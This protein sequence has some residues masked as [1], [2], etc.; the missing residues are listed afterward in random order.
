MRRLTRVLLGLFILGQLAF[1]LTANLADLLGLAST[2]L[3]QMPPAVRTPLEQVETASRLAR[4]AETLRGATSWWA[5]LTDQPQE[6]ALFAPDVTDRIP[7]VNVELSWEGGPVPDGRV[8]DPV[9]LPS[10]N[11]PADPGHFFRLGRFRLRRYEGTVDVTPS[12]GEDFD[13]HGE[14]W[15]ADIRRAV[16][17]RASWMRAYLSWRVAAFRESHPNLPPPTQAI[18]HVRLYQVPAPPG[19]SPW[20]WHD[21][22]RHPVARWL[23]GAGAPPGTHHLERYDPVEERFE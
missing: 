5:D 10:V 15:R 1:L 12:S 4:G 13:P 20:Y 9:I 22:G 2:S 17:A 16:M 6:W 8:L 11:E 3:P 7:F 23:P 19:P 14:E 18:L 21:L